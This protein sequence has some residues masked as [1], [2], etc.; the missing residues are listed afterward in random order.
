MEITP[1][2]IVVSVFYCCVLT[3]FAL[4]AQRTLYRR[5][6]GVSIWIG[7]CIACETSS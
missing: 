1:Q 5:D 4:G 7:M 2:P 6:G 3:R